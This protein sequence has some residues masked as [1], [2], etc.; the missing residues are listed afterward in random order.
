LFPRHGRELDDLVNAADV[1]MYSAKSTGVTYRL[2]DV[3]AVGLAADELRSSA[4]Y[5]GPDRRR[6]PSAADAVTR[7]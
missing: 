3:H 5:S 4:D 6:H 1:A 7:D 2:A